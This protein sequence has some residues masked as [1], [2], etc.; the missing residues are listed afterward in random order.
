MISRRALFLGTTAAA[1]APA[2]RRITQDFRI[3]HVEA[4]LEDADARVLT[5]IG[6]RNLQLRSEHVGE[7][8]TLTIG[9]RGTTGV[10]RYEDLASVEL[11]LMDGGEAFVSAWAY[12]VS[13]HGYIGYSPGEDLPVVLEHGHGEFWTL[14]LDAQRFPSAT[15][16]AKAAQI[17]F[18]AGRD[19]RL[20]DLDAFIRRFCEVLP[21]DADLLFTAN[22][23]EHV[24]PGA[25]LS[26]FGTRA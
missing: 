14:P 24:P 9:V 11:E 10:L 3:R 1:L 5:G 18:I 16:R 8:P 7:P 23:E 13:W 12:P 21:E 15:A 6:A 17:A 2:P 4:L 19:I 22:V 25:Y 26:L 20:Q